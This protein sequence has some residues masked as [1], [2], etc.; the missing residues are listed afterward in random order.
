MRIYEL[1]RRP[2]ERIVGQLNKEELDELQ[3]E[4]WRII[5]RPSFVKQS[6]RNK[7]GIRVE[8]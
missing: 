7:N 5:R 1:Q 6:R 2:Q 8:G 3:L 4:G